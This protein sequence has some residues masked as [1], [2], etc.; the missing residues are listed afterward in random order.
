MTGR[1]TTLDNNSPEISADSESRA[2]LSQGKGDDPNLPDGC[3][4]CQDAI[5]RNSN[6]WKR[7]SG[8]SCVVGSIAA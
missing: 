1:S 7:L 5:R 6:I 4:A 2:L 8:I 3:L